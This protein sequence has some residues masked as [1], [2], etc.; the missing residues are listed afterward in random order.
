MKQK[1][2]SNMT[3]TASTTKPTIQSETDLK[4]AI[5]RIQD[6]WNDEVDHSSLYGGFR[7]ANLEDLSDAICTYWER[8]GRLIL[9]DYEKLVDILDYHAPGTEISAEVLNALE[10]KFGRACGGGEF[11]QPRF[12]NWAGNGDCI[13]LAEF[14]SDHLE[15][16]VREQVDLAVEALP[17]FGGNS[18]EEYF[19]NSW[20]EQHDGWEDLSWEEQKK[21]FVK[22]VYETWNQ[23]STDQLING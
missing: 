12:F 13:A 8:S 20:N 5:D 3:S 1:K 2:T 19:S 4:W 11:S 15:E 21:L 6:E 17:K 22:D 10:E 18:V 14:A 9:N 23:E 16:W 7:H